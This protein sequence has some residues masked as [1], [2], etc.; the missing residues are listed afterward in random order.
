MPMLPSCGITHKCLFWKG[1]RKGWGLSQASSAFLSCENPIPVPA[2]G[3]QRQHAKTV[4][5]IGVSGLH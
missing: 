5:L 2:A 4:E 1:G 3:W